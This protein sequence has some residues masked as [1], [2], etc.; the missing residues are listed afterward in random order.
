MNACIY[1]AMQSRL[2][3]DERF[4]EMHLLSFHNWTTGS[5]ASQVLGTFRHLCGKAKLHLETWIMYMR[6][7]TL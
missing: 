7:F 5:H 2:I 1:S 4:S 3:R 6:R